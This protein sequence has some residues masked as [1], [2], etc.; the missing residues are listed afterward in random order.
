MN[1]SQRLCGWSPRGAVR[2]ALEDGAG[3][4]P[5][6]GEPVAWWLGSVMSRKISPEVPALCL[7]RTSLPAFLGLAPPQY[8]SAGRAGGHRKTGE[9]LEMQDPEPTSTL[10]IIMTEVLF[11]GK[12]RTSGLGSS[13]SSDA[14][15][16]A[17][18][19]WEVGRS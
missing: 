16:T 6:S 11:G 14:E 5:A 15:R 12:F 4:P 17:L 3:P 13:I 1:L 8:Q 10:K 19:G 9:T 18:R 2:V 7:T